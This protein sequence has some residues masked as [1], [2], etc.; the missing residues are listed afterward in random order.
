MDPATPPFD[1][2][3][4][5]PV[6]TAPSRPPAPARRPVEILLVDDN[7][8]D[9][10]F[11]RQ[12]LRRT[13]VHSNLTVARD[14]EEALALLAGPSRPDLMLL[15]LNMPRM[16]GLEVL[17][18]VKSDPDLRA[19]PVIVLTSSVADADVERAYESHVNAYIRKPVDLDDLTRIIEAIDQFWCT[20]AVLPGRGSV[21][22]RS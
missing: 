19:I 21:D 16:G 20:V 8:A 3:D 17:E 11:T 18:V 15:D 14:G 6:T 12:V 22:A 1:R 2:S 10:V 7:P 13:Q 4:G 9:V 5:S